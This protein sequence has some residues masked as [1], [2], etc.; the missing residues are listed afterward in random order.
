MYVIFRNKYSKYL[1]CI[2]ANGSTFLAFSQNNF[3]QAFIVG[4]IVI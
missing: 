1:G 4:G 2:G 3:Y